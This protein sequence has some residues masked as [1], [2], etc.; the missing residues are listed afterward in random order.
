MKLL[1]LIINKWKYGRRK[2]VLKEE[3]ITG[4][5][6]YSKAFKKRISGNANKEIINN[7]QLTTRNQGRYNSCTGFATASLVEAITKKYLLKKEEIDIANFSV[8][9]K[10]TW[11]MGQKMHG[12]EGTNNGVWLRYTLESLFEDGFT[13]EKYC[14]Y[15]KPTEE[16][17]ILA[18][19]TAK[20]FKKLLINK[21]FDKYLLTVDDVDDC[22]SKGYPVVCGLELNNSW[23][24]T[25]D[26]VTAEGSPNGNNHA[27]L[28]T[29]KVI[30]NE[31]LMYKAHNSWGSWNSDR[32]SYYVPL[33]YFRNNAYNLW[34]IKIRPRRNNKK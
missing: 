19:A 11:Y 12:W 32:G 18:T 22:L 13:R 24:T 5:E 8:S 30:K 7:F 33:N 3:K 10:Y 34:T 14:P 9:P 31:R 15:I 17:T 4:V 26:G 2:G 23:Y 1:R 16:P 20:L 6:K 28:I 25:K 21:R 27:I 29:D